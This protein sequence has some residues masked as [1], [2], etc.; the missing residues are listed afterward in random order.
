MPRLGSHLSIAGGYWKAPA[1]AAALQMDAVQIFTKS[2]AQ[3]AAKPLSD[4]DTERF[5][6]ECKRHALRPNCAHASY[7]INLAAV[8]EALR[9]RSIDAMKI[10][11]TRAAAFGLSGVVLHPGAHTKSL[12]S[13][14]V[15]NVVDSLDQVHRA[16]PELSVEI[17]L[18]CT[19]GQ[20]TCLGHRLD[21]LA[22]MITR[23]ANPGRLGVCLDTCHLSAAGYEF[24]TPAAYDHFIDEI[25]QT[26]G[27]ARV[28]AWHLNDSKHPCGS[29]KDRHEHIGEGTLGDEPFRHILNDPR[30]AA[31]PM[32][33]ET[34]KE[35]R[36]GEPMDA[37]NL[38]RLR[39]LIDG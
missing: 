21:E 29:R 36:N 16:L 23:S 4:A 3:W 11:L 37:V 10:E 2:N 17:W 15:D 14:G 30:F 34:K 35:D 31:L 25:E 27:V 20:G 39:S 13:E 1:A 5:R 33:L 6:D 9:E 38:R 8:D 18:E 26:I 19:A 12:R 22:E 32:Y 28:R 24:S 7:L